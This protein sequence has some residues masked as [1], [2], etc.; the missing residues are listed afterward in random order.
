[1]DDAAARAHLAIAIDVDDLVA[2]VR[3]AKQVQPYFGVAKVGLELYSAAGPDAFG[4]MID[5]GFEVFADLKLHDIPTTV[6]KAARVI[7]A[8]GVTWLNFH[9]S[10]GDA[11][12]RAGVEGFL[13]GASGAGLELPVPLGVTV[14]TSDHDAPPA[15]LAERASVAALAG[16]GG[17]VCAVADIPTIR[18]VAPNLVCVTPGIRPVG[19][20][21]N[22]QER[23]ATPAEAIAAG[24]DLLVVGRPVTAA[25][26]PAAAARAVHDEVAS[27]LQPAS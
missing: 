27:A 13:G 26:D 12:L 5:L 24:A 21:R 15:L 8:L 14:L 4:A 20:D 9:T 17:V 19:A 16:C 22:D 18:A 11:M 1:M 6:G 25:P 2:A 23:A 10:G 7:G 3:L